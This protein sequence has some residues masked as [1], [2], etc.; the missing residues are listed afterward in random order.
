MKHLISKEEAR[1]HAKTLQDS[2]GKS[3]AGSRG[4]VASDI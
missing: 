1:E 4:R 3:N 2:L